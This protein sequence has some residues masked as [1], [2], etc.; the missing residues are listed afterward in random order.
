MDKPKL[1]NSHDTNLDSEY[2][3]WIHEIKV[4][5]RNTQSKAAVKVNSEQLLFNW[6]LGRDLVV[7]KAEKNGAR[8]LLNSLVW[9]CKKN[10]PKQRDLARQI[11]GT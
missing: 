6:L 10:F 8:A 5:Y 4:R 2:I 7:R 3:A 1:V 9:I 11:F